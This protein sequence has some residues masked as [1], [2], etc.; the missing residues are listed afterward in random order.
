MSVALELH[1]PEQL[2]EIHNQLALKEVKERW[3]ELVNNKQATAADHVYYIA[4]RATLAK[5]PVSIEDVERRLR[6]AFSPI[7]NRRKIELGGCYPRQSLRAALGFAIR[8]SKRDNK[9][10]GLK[11]NFFHSYTNKMVLEVL[12]QVSAHD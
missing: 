9:V 6:A 10:S 1:T 5:N 3:S 11:L 2:E 7:T 12:M 4:C 8:M